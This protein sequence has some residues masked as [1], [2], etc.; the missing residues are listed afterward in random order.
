MAYYRRI[1]APPFDRVVDHLWVF[2]GHE[3]PAERG[4]LFADGCVDLMFNLSDALTMHREGVASHW[5]GAWISGQRTAPIG[6]QLAARR[7]TMV[8]ARLRPAGI[9]A[10]LGAP[11][12]EVVN[13]VV[14]LRQFWRRETAEA[15]DRLA[16][17]AGPRA[18]LAA[19]ADIL[20]HRLGNAALPAAPLAAAVDDIRAQPA[21]CSIERVRDRLGVSH[22]HLTR[23]FESHVGLT[24][25]AFQ[26]VCRFRHLLTRIARERRQFGWAQFALACGYADQTHLCSEFRAF[27]GLTPTRYHPPIL[28]APDYMPWTPPAGA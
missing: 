18:R 21:R 11:A 8:G 16:A 17:A 3:V 15:I 26:R 19:L 1:L 6:I 27:A 20:T 12:A 4:L 25:K 5:A 24:P 13:L 7:F 14:D 22:K 10:V 9:A 28:D 2:E 23:L